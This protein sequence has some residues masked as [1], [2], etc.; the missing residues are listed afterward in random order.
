VQAVARDILEVGLHRYTEQG[1]YI[2][3]HVHDEIIAVEEAG[4]ADLALDLL[5]KAMA[6][7]IDWAPGLLLGAGGYTSERYRKD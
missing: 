6:D 7:P 2:V 1:G 5:V 3:G 4:K